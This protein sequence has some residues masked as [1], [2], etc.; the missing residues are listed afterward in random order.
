MALTIT[1]RPGARNRVPGHPEQGSG[2]AFPVSR[3]NLRLP[4]LGQA[5]AV[6]DAT[7]THYPIVA[8]AN[9]LI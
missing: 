2:D 4:W 1:I 8:R 5:Q 6:A 9:A 3:S 7:V